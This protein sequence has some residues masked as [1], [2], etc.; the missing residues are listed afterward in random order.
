M[1]NNTYDFTISL[2]F[3]NLKNDNLCD[4]FV[5]KTLAG[6]PIIIYNTKKT[7]KVKLN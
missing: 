1:D 3:L 6:K 7:I 5:F 4:V 2:F